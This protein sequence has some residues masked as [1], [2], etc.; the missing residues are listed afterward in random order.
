MSYQPDKQYTEGDTD[1]TITGNAQMLEKDSDTLT[2]QKDDAGFGE[3][4]TSGIASVHARVWD[5]SA[6]DRMKGDSTD[7]VLVN[8]GSN[9]DVTV[10]G[11]V[12]AS[13]STATN[14]KTQAEAY[15]G[16]SAVA[17]GNPLEVNLRSSTVSVATSTKQ[18][19]G[20]QKT[21]VVDGSGNVIGATSNALDINIK[22]GNPTSITANAGT[23]LNTS[24]LALES[25]G[26][27]AASATSLGVMDDWD[28]SDRAKVNIITGQAGVAAGVGAS[29]STTQRVVQANDSG[30]TIVSK[31]GS[32]ASSGDNTL[33]SAGSNKLKVFAFSLTTTSTTAVTCIFQSGASGTELW[34]V[35][36]QAGTG[37]STGANLSVTLPS[38]LFATASATLLNLNLSSAQTV[39]YSLS[40]IDEA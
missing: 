28:E 4:L 30:K 19:D 14:L 35:V 40:Y 26:N 22:S 17:S 20:S 3:N 31:G 8:L 13:Q 2:A 10:T 18:S 25:G 36:L 24:T 33:V 6:Y 12:T 21:Q 34:R 5:G 23:N 32:V 1:S 9:S 15:Q 37:T 11:S 29:G 16:G 27:L 7:G 39:H 38:Y